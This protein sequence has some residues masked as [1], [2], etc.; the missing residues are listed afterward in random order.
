VKLRLDQKQLADAAR[1]AHRRLPSKPLQPVLSGL[2]LEA[3][4]DTVTLSGFDLDTAT[5]A[6]LDAEILEPGEAVISG[7]LLA[8]VSAALPAGPVDLVADEREATITAPGTS[9]TLPVMERR[10]YPALPVPPGASGTVDGDLLAAA[11]GHAAQAAMPEKEA[12]GNMLGFGGVRIQSDGDQLVAS[13]SDRYRIVRHTVPWRPDGDEPGE[14]LIPAAGIAATVKQMA[15]HEIRISFTGS[16]GV[17]ALATDQLTVTS[18]TI[19]GEFPDITRF[20]PDP[21]AAAGWMR[22]EAGEL[23]AAVQR[24]SLVNEKP[25]QPVV[26]VFGRDEV[27]VRGGVEGSR[28][29]SRIPAETADLD[30]FEIAYRPDFLSSL[31]AP[32]GGQVQMWFTTAS[33]PALLVPVND[34][35]YRAVCMPVRLPK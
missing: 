30:K 8:D 4:G 12:V 29:A 28:G 18:R 31:L 1:R 15:G 25:E 13:A 20:F 16:R 21:D 32:I 24:A 26:L 7:R 9:F 27:T 11:V 5:R 23:A 14:L 17:A 2:L 19:A 6:T 33:K 35:T 3:A 10:D 22:A 34:D